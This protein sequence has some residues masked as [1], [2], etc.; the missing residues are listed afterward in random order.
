MANDKPKAMTKSAIM[1]ELATAT[2]LKKA[3]VV[4]LYNALLDMIHRQL[5]KKGPGV[6]TLP[7]LL[8]LTKKF[9]PAVPARTGPHPITKVM[10]TFKA[11]PARNVV[12]ARALKALNDAIK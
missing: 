12:K 9:K 6:F 11:K 7:G 3:Q 2:S 4:E 10:T 1:Q 8:K 5:G